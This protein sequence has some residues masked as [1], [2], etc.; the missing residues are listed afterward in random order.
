MW[1]VMV[2]MT[3]VYGWVPCCFDISTAFLQGRRITRNVYLHPRPSMVMK[4]NKSVYSLV[5]AP[6]HWYEARNEG[7]VAIGGVRLRYHKCA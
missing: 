4:L 6:W 7:I 3:A 1:R 5:D 2:A